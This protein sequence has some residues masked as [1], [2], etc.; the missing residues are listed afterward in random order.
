[1]VAALL[2]VHHDIEKGDWLGASLVQLL[3]VSGQNPAIEF[4][5]SMRGRRGEEREEGR[6]KGK[7]RKG[8]E[9][10]EGRGKGKKRKG[11][12]GRRGEEET[13]EGEEGEA[14]RGHERTKKVRRE[15]KRN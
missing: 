10:E 8:E 5:V 4:P 13:V 9:R 15:R 14:E 6:G 2:E 11:E 3:K 1:M 12:G 7:K